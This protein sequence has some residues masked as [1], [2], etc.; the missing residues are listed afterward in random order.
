MREL[1]TLALVVAIA[2]R[3]ALAS[4]VVDDQTRRICIKWPNDVVLVGEECEACAPSST[5]DTTPE[6][7]ENTPCSDSPRFAAELRVAHPRQTQGLQAG[8]EKLASIKGLFSKLAGISSEVHAGGICVGIG[9][10][11]EPPEDAMEVGGKNAGVSGR[12]WLRVHLRARSCDQRRGRCGSPRVRAPVSPLVRRRVRS[13][14]GR[15]RRAFDARGAF[16]PYGQPAGRCRLRGHGARGRC[17]RAAAPPTGRRR[18]ESRCFGRGAPALASRAPQCTSCCA[19]SWCTSQH[20]WPARTPH[21]AY[22]MARSS[23]CVARFGFPAFPFR[24]PFAVAFAR[25]A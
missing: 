7:G 20:A 13:A 12:P 8:E 18:D 24:L 9:V 4:L 21:L 16:R 6:F 25:W 10:N 3:R 19:W 22:S 15:V 14:F 5:C 2:V 1:P 17:V 23:S 11:V